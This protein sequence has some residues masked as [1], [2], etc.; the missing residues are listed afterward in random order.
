MGDIRCQL[1]AQTVAV[2]DFSTHLI[3]SLAQFAQF[4]LRAHI[5]PLGQVSCCQVLCG[6]GQFD[7][8]SGQTS[9]EQDAGQCRDQYRQQ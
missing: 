6:C 4:I 7:Y 2:F 3:E 9:R 8:G 1:F 5:H